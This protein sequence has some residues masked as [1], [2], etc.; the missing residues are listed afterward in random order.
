MSWLLLTCSVSDS[1]RIKVFVRSKIAW[2]TKKKIFNWISTSNEIMINF[3]YQYWKLCAC[4]PSLISDP[5]YKFPRRKDLLD[6]M[7]RPPNNSWE[8]LGMP[9]KCWSTNDKWTDLSCWCLLWYLDQ[10]KIRHCWGK[11]SQS[12]F[13]V[14]RS[15]TIYGIE[16]PNFFLQHSKISS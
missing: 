4:G 12:Y 2:K 14:H 13:L 10:I 6:K 16:N 11:K 1:D 15:L 5:S 8:V 7:I 9:I 3:L